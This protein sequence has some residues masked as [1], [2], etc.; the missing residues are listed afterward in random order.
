MT[1]SDRLKALINQWYAGADTL[2]P[3]HEF[4]A[5]H[6]VTAPTECQVPP[7]GW[8]CTRDPGHEGPCAAWPVDISIPTAPDM[9]KLGTPASVDVRAVLN[10]R[11]RDLVQWW[12]IQ[13][14]CEWILRKI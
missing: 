11:N 2:L 12:Q 9:L 3:L 4:L 1:T 14:L 5:K 6:G 8:R 10:T 7:A 13:S